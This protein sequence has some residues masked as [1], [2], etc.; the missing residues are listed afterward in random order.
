MT[1]VVMCPVCGGSGFVTEP[2][3]GPADDATLRDRDQT[4]TDQDQTWSDHD[5]TASDR[6]Q[7]SANE[8]QEAS[9]HDFADGG[10]PVIHE[11]TSLARMRSS[12]DRDEVSRLRDESS[13]TRLETSE[14]RDQS[15]ELRDRDAKSRDRLAHLHDLQHDTE[16]SREDILL[17]AERDRARAAADRAK[18][19]EDRSRA[20]ADRKE[21]ASQRAEA[22]RAYG[23]ARH[24]LELAATD[25]VTGAWTRK[26][27]L[28]EVIREIERARRTGNGLMLAFI[29]VDGLK[30]VNDTQGHPA[31]DQLLHLIVETVRANVRPYDVI[32]RYGGDEFL[33]AM[34]NLTRAGTKQRMDKIT[35]AL[36]E[37]DEGHSITFGLAEYEPADGLQEF[38]SRAD[39]DLLNA[40]RPR[41]GH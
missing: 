26:F 10:N 9:D 29:D 28:A 11:R 34:P 24:N 6:D 39:A 40:R 21:A 1:E 3:S 12:L 38:I 30:E 17:R 7:R 14:D 13:E 19:A 23:E 4:A 18:A 33:C 27:G 15:A 41:E 16:A 32:V 22:R 20:A 5:Q 25:E 37:A 31:G 36:T 35:A 8:D 2:V